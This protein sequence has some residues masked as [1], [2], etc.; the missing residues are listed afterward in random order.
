ML[1]L[2]WSININFLRNISFIKAT[3]LTTIIN[4]R[5]LFIFLSWVRIINIIACPLWWGG[6]I[7]KI[8]NSFENTL[9]KLCACFDHFNMVHLLKS[10]DFCLRNWLHI[11]TLFL[12]IEIPICILDLAQNTLFIVQTNIAL[13]CK[14]NEFNIFEIR[15]FAEVFHP[16]F[17][18]SVGIFICQTENQH[19]TLSKF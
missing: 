5:I 3:W 1:I 12:I 7:Y 4:L 6:L 17:G 2:I 9:V 18:T 11:K 16:F 14:N 8:I 15:L 19:Y 13:V 10:F